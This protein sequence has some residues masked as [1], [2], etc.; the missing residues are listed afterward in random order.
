MAFD[1]GETDTDEVSASN[2]LF[3]KYRGTDEPECSEPRCPEPPRP[4]STSR[5]APG[6]RL[7][8][9]DL[10][11]ERAKYL[12]RRLHLALGD[13]ELADIVGDGWVHAGVGVIHFNGLDLRQAERLVCRLEDIAS[14]PPGSTDDLVSDALVRKGRRA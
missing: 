2:G 9:A 12:C 14:A 13:L 11:A 1:A 7:A 4:P 10:G 6:M 8:E 5:P 3:R